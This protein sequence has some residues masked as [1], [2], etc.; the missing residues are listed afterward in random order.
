MTNTMESII[1]L[2]RIFMQYASRLI[3]L[4]VVSESLTIMCAPTQLINRIQLYTVN[5]MTGI[6]Q[7]MMLSARTNML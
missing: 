1:R 5:I 6:L 4:P 7:A 3:R 2:I